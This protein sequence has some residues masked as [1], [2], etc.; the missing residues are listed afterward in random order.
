MPTLFLH[1]FSSHSPVMKDTHSPKDIKQLLEQIE[2]ENVI[3]L[4]GIVINSLKNEKNKKLAEE[5]IDCLDSSYPP[6]NSASS[7]SDLLN[8]LPVENDRAEEIDPIDESLRWEML[9]HKGDSGVSAIIDTHIIG[10]GLSEHKINGVEGCLLNEIKLTSLQTKSDARNIFGNYFRYKGEKGCDLCSIK[11]SDT[12]Y[13]TISLW[14]NKLGK[15]ELIACK[16]SSD[17][18][19][20]QDI[21]SKLVKE[22]ERI[23][24]ILERCGFR[25][26]KMIVKYYV[27]TAAGGRKNAIKYLEDRKVIL[28]KDDYLWK[29]VLPETLK[30]WMRKEKDRIR[31]QRAVVE[32]ICKY[33]D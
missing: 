33:I 5:Y 31:K 2:D 29:N 13:L 30:A 15:S 3:A 4:F 1:Q 18:R 10:S 22:G 25:K 9:T 24:T 12:G 8:E 19:R 17:N 16:S 26:S 20:V 11:E 6:P 28:L 27:L 23:K 21:Y 32:W 7:I 14:S